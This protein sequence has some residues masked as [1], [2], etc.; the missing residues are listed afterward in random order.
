MPEDIAETMAELRRLGRQR[1]TAR[2]RAADLSD[3]MQPL[4]QRAHAAGV[5]LA[6]LERVTGITRVTLRRMARGDRRW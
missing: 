2:Q 1:E 6:E 5:S 3:R 4:V